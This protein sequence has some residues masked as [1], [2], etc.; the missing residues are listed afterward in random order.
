MFSVPRRVAIAALSVALNGCLDPCGNE[1]KIESVSPDGAKRAVVF[2]RSCGA[3]TP[4]STHVSVLN[5]GEALPGSAGNVFD[6][7]GNHGA[8][9]D[10][11]VTVRWVSTRQLVLR[12]P[13]GARVFVRNGEVNA[14]AIEY[15]PVP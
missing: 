4:F 11:I 5:A 3:T 6:A 9:K 14:V 8:V 7:D 2:E 15:E 1:I 10:V 13:A 12:Y